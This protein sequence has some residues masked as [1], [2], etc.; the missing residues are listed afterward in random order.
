MEQKKTLWIIAA[1]GVFLL[2][3][4][5][6][7]RIIYSPL[8]N[9]PLNQKV[10]QAQAPA[11]QSGWTNPENG[12]RTPDLKQPPKVSDMYVVSENT[13]VYEL[14]NNSE[15]APS[16]Q[17]TTI[18]LNA[19]KK[20][21]SEE[22]KAGQSAEAPQVA[23]VAPSSGQPNNQNI[24]ITVNIPETEKQI[25][26]QSPVVVSSDYYIQSTTENVTE[27]TPVVVQTPAPVVEKEEKPAP[28]TPA[29]TE[30][31]TSKTTSKKV[32][33]TTTV[34][35]T[36]NVTSKPVTRFWVQAA[37]YSNKKTAEDARAK[38]TANKINSDIYTYQDNKN[39]LFYRVRIGPF[40][41]KSEAEYWKA[42]IIEIPDFAKAGSYVTSTTD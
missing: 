38:L 8:N 20:E 18:D 5:G 7:A 22:L 14:T 9:N 17:G 23:P 3:V 39:K 21:I 6:F 19:L 4:L 11:P 27:K 26:V 10:S 42:K 33:T 1:V 34:N 13:S 41:T 25:S 16:S 12:M 30:V 35:A 32:N 24:N 37:A 28:K 36:T 40:T 31:K 29:K 2:I 15:A